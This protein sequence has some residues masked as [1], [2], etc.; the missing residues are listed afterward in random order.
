MRGCLLLVMLLGAGVS[1]GQ[2]LLAN[3]GF[4][5]ENICTEFRQNCA[6]EAWIATS[7]RANYYF[8]EP[9]KAQEGTH[10]VGLVAGNLNNADA[11]NF[12]RSRLICSLRKG[13]RYKL[14]LYVR[15]LNPVLDSIGVYFSKTDFL[16]A[17]SSFKALRP[18][19]WAV[20]GADA[21]LHTVS[22]QQL[23]W[24]YEANGE[25]IFILIG[26]F[27]KNVPGNIS[28]AE[29]KNDYYFFLDNVSLIPMDPS[30]KICPGADSIRQ[31]IFSD[32]MR[33][34]LL[35]KKVYVEKRKQ[36][37]SPPMQLTLLQ[38]KLMVDTLIVPDVFFATGSSRISTEGLQ[39]LDSFANRLRKLMP[40]SVLVEGHTDSIGKLAYNE[41]LS[42]E[43]AFAVMHYL[44]AKSSLVYMKWSA[45]G[46]SFL[47]PVAFNATSAG[48][49][50]NRRVEI[51]VYSSAPR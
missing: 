10:F 34:Q 37:L 48:R 13:H 9:S 46:W 8:D 31:V 35:E 38:P 43:R 4:E 1:R 51:Y 33:H 30:E 20:D 2:N 40:D 14:Q 22:W 50:R 11:R 17:Q 24:E 26:S 25:E 45:R 21:P 49:Q 18:Q 7:L 32:D 19:L 39:V 42:E 6:P 16:Y 12:V 5:Q 23:T 44:Q 15:S 41:K 36:Q 29:Y 3:G 28:S 47:K 27:H